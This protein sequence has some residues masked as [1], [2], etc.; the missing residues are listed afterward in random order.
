M[1]TKEARGSLPTD[2]FADSQIWRTMSKHPFVVSIR[3]QCYP[4]QGVGS[5]RLQFSKSAHLEETQNTIKRGQHDCDW[6]RLSGVCVPFVSFLPCMSLVPVLTFLMCA[7]FGVCV[8]LLRL[9]CPSDAHW[10]YA[11]MFAVEVGFQI[12]DQIWIPQPRL[13][14]AKYF[15]KPQNGLFA[16]FCYVEFLSSVFSSFRGGQAWYRQFELKLM[17]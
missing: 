13:H 9:D 4:V 8:V 1:H 16:F 14:G 3:A 11:D 2:L 7:I 6:N 10:D 15:V 5:P 12:R 17:F